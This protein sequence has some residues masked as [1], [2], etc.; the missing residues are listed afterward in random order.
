MH[1]DAI[2]PD[3][4]ST[5]M[6]LSLEDKAIAHLPPEKRDFWSHFN[7]IMRSR[8]M[9]DVFLKHLEKEIT[10][11]FRKPLREIPCHPTVR[12]GRDADG[13]KILPHP[14]SADRVYT[15]QVYLADDDSQE[16]IEAIVYRK[17]RDGSFEKVRK[18]PFLP[19]TAFCFARTD[20]TWHGVEA[21]TLKKPRQNLHI[22]CF[23]SDKGF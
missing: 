18:F 16:D 19:N 17:L 6:T 5:R 11:R 8:P 15:A 10:A 7:K 13:Y 2:K 21:V 12:L 20:E 3:G 4:S 23:M 22:S 1:P 9:L 14:D